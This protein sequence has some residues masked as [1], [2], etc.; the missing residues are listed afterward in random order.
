M[1]SSLRVFYHI[2]VLEILWLLA[3]YATINRLE[4]SNTQKIN[5]TEQQIDEFQYDAFAI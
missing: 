2:D 3:L 1:N 5:Q 4:I